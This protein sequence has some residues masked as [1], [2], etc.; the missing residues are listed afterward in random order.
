MGKKGL[1]VVFAVSLLLFAGC[2]DPVPTG[3]LRSVQVQK[4][5]V[6]FAA[7]ESIQIAFVVDEPGYVFDLVSDVVLYKANSAQR[8]PDEI[9][10]KEVLPDAEKGHYIAVIADT[11]LRNDY[12]LSVLLG[13]RGS[14]GIYVFSD[15]FEC[16]GGMAVPH[17]LVVETGLPTLY[18][19]TSGGV[20]I[21][22]KTDYV[23]ASLLIREPDAKMLPNPLPCTVR[24]RGNTT[25]SWPKKPYLV[26]LDEK[27]SLLGMPS[28]KRWVLLANFMDRTLMRNLV[29]MK[30]SSMTA[31]DW[32]P[33]CRSVELVL[34]GRH[35]GTYLLIEQVR[36]S[37]DRVPAGDDG[38]L[39]ESDFHFDN[40]VQWMDP[41]GRC[42]QMSGGIPFGVKYPD[43]DDL[44]TTQRMEIVN[45]ISE[46][47][48]IIYGSSFADP[49]SGYASRIDVDSFIDYWIVFEVMGN[50]E[51]GNPGSVFYHRSP[52]GK[53]IA[54][55]CWDFDWGVL[56]YTANPAARNG[57]LNRNAC[58]YSRLFDD[59]AFRARVKA[60]FEELLPQLQTIP[61]YIDELEKQLGPS[62]EL[63]FQ[64]WN[65]A[66]DASMNGGWIIN[67][68]ENMTFKD[69]VARLRSIYQER[70]EVIQKNL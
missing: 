26:R 54:G 51:L 30:V 16:R 24:G 25:W 60:R 70:L 37:K 66:Q 58:W 48:G 53:L 15:P 2:E 13:I 52:G 7:N 40:E 49:V 63:N 46:T 14:N 29:A 20:P 44:T 47:A 61:A 10:L 35:M 8:F 68:D 42:V 22:S 12:S 19:D 59:P 21:R 28:H 67:G 5:V 38:W 4:T 34:N 64:M 57:L 65:P 18:L 69:A 41:H 50:H 31:L 9:Q 1:L 33:R 45:F 17:G 3:V 43:P 6:T 55:P 62:A 23:A 39:L 56:S 32:T 36:V 11:G 27:A